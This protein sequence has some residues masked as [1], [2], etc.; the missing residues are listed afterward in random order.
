MTA[1]SGALS[2]LFL[3]VFLIFGGLIVLSFLR[4]V[5][6]LSR[7][8]EVLLILF[9]SIGSYVGGR[10]IVFIGC[11]VLVLICLACGIATLLSAAALATCG[12]TQPV[13]LCHLVGR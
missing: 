3:I 4:F 11:A 9:D 2:G 1:N 10:R 12:T 13:Q 5:G 6:R 8:L 7:P